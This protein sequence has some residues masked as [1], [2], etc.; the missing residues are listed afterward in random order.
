MLS[1]TEHGK[2]PIPT[3]AFGPS[4]RGILLMIESKWIMGRTFVQCRIVNRPIWFPLFRGWRAAKPANGRR[5]LVA[6]A[7]LRNTQ[8]ALRSGHEFCQR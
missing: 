4:A 6:A 1:Y 3:Q 2:L 8:S 7:G 5:R